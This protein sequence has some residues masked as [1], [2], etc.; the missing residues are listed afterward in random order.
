MGKK[1]SRKT[2]ISKGQR[3]NVTKSTLKLAAASVTGFAKEAQLRRA[4]RRGTN[5]W[6]TVKNSALH[7]NREYYKVRANDYWGHPKKVSKFYNI[8]KGKSE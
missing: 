3:P 6:I 4:W 8:Y 7:T 5:P 1:R 2:Y